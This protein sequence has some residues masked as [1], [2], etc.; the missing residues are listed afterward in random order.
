MADVFDK[1]KRSKLMGLVKAKN[2]K[3]EVLLRKGLHALG[4]RFG[5][6]DSRLPGKPDIKLS[7]YKTVIF[8]NGCFWHGHPSCKYYTIP[9]T[10]N[11]FWVDKIQTNIKRDL[12]NYIALRDLGWKIIIIWTC[13]LKKSKISQTLINI[14]EILKSI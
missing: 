2:T 11:E 10:N 8:V 4:F 9:E 13:E 1:E 5:L 6:H 14:V 12:Q 7:K 3:P